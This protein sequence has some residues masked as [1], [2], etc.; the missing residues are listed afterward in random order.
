M[1]TNLF[2]RVYCKN[3]CGKQRKCCRFSLAR[4]AAD[5][6]VPV[7]TV[8]V[9][10]RDVVCGLV[11]IVENNLSALSNVVKAGESLGIRVLYK[12]FTLVSD[13]TGSDV[14]INVKLT[15]LHHQ[16]AAL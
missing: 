7:V 10:P 6:N 9:L 14:K 4:I 3:R 8:K 5:D 13:I 16:I 15:S 11:T 1:C 2:N 12:R